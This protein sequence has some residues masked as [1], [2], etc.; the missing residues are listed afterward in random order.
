MNELQAGIRKGF[1]NEQV[2]LELAECFAVSGQHNISRRAYFEAL[3]RLEQRNGD[4]E[5]MVRALYG[6]AHEDIQLGNQEEAISNLEYLLLIKSDYRDARELVEQ[7]YKAKQ[8]STQSKSDDVA[9]QVLEQIVAM[10]G[11]KDE[12]AGPGGDS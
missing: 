5:L 3:K 12:Q 9:S 11:K 8:A 6:L 7:L 10:L 1:A 2:F 4:S